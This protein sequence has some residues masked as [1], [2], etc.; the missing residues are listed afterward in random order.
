[1]TS[2]YDLLTGVKIDDL[3]VTD[4]DSATGRTFVDTQTIE[5]WQ[6][7]LTLSH[8]L[9]GAR[10]YPHGLPMPETGDVH[11]ETIANGASATVGP[12]GSEIWVVENIDVD[13]CSVAF[14][15][16]EGHLS[17]ITRDAQAQ[18]SR[19]YISSTLK[20]AFS[21]SSGSEQ[22]PSIAYLKVSL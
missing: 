21:N 3:K 20:L 14:I 22:T 2:I 4:L 6:G 17:P 5:F 15:D 10:T 16:T 18:W 13:N 1:M 19:F 9:K 8:V 11:I 7:I 12:S